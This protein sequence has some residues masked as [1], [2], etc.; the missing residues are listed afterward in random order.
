LRNNKIGSA[1]QGIL[2]APFF[3]GMM[4]IG[5]GITLAVYGFFGEG[6]DSRF[7]ESRV[8]M[9][10]TAV[11]FKEHNFFNE[12]FNENKEKFFEVCGFD[13]DVLEDGRHIIYVKNEKNNEEFFVGVYDFTI[14]CGITK[15]NLGIPECISLVEDDYEIL[16]GTSQNS[17][18]VSEP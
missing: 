5:L 6:Y 12:N 2:F 11:C 15:K 16:V 8:L 4:I 3:L 18:R 7:S 13:K 1:S 17:W 9:E 10:K 14:R